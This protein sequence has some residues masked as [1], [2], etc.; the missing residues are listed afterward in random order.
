M[1]EARKPT[2]NEVFLEVFRGQIDGV[3]AEIV[4]L[5]K[6]RLHLVRGAAVVKDAMGKDTVQPDRRD[7]VLQARDEALQNVGYPAGAG[8]TIWEGIHAASVVIQDEVR[9]MRRASAP[10][11]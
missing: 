3:D 4:R 6:K 2:T 7:A 11:K 8:Q 10:R 9:S 1:T 5:L